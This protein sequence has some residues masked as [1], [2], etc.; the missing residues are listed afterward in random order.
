MTLSER[1]A[2]YNLAR[3]KYGLK[4]QIDQL[5]EEALELALA[6][7]RYNR[8]PDNFM[9]MELADEIADIE[10][11]TEQISH[12]LDSYGLNKLVET[13]KAFK[14]ARLSKRLGGIQYVKITDG[15]DLYPNGSYQPI[16]DEGASY[17][18]IRPNDF[19]KVEQGVAV[20]ALPENHKA[21]LNCKNVFDHEAYTDEYC[22][23]CE[24]R[25]SKT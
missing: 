6:A 3:T 9:L 17:F 13:R 15:C 14:L 4:A 11:M 25:K 16:I 18:R 5:N 8:A 12:L 2:L 21:C 10:I 1:L 20:D 19:I 22:P 24:N 23:R 7:R